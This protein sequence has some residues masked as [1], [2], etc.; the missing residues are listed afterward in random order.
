V[1]EY[2]KNFSAEYKRRVLANRLAFDS[3]GLCLILTKVYSILFYCL[4]ADT[5]P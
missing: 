2:I 3:E 5:C 4:L 1:G